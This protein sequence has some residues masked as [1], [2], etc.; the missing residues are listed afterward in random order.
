MVK[1]SSMDSVVE[2][3]KRGRK[4]KNFYAETSIPI[5]EPETVVEKKKRGRKK[6][7]EIENF[8]K[9]VN[10]DQI[11]NFNHNIAYS[12]D[13]SSENGSVA[14]ESQTKSISFGNLNI[15]VNKKTTQSN[16]DMDY[17]SNIISSCKSVIDINEYSEEEDIEVPI[18]NILSLNQDKFE[19]Y[20]KDKNKYISENS[21]PI[22]KKDQSLKRF[23]VITTLKNEI[24]E[25]EWPETT[26]VCCWWCCHQFDTCPC[27]LPTKYDPL[28]KRFTF[29]GVFCSWNC[30]KAYNFDKLDHRKAERSELIT[31]LVKELYSVEEAICINPAP[32][33]QCLKMFGGY[34]TIEEFRDQ[35]NCVDSYLMNL[36]K[37]NYVHPEITEVT[38][39]KITQP[40]KNLR[41]SRN[42]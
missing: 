24:T 35:Q 27:T 36:I 39:V 4:P 12:D 33:R 20:Y 3:K 40:K 5:Q 7:Y 26:D 37:Y 14:E 18:E 28:R 16:I 32:Y 30:A 9:I 25:N 42:Q 6:K 15:T 21:V 17:R 10:R 1:L 19:K 29:I 2:K 23:R 8:D 38:N 22:T 13:S 31:L 41:L 11:N 34:M